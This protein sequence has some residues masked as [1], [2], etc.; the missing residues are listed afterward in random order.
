MP[1][2]IYY[3]SN[4]L[5]FTK[6]SLFYALVIIPNCTPEKDV[7]FE[8]LSTLHRS[9]GVENR[10]HTQ[11]ISRRFQVQTKRDQRIRK[12]RHKMHAAFAK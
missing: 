1:I 2:R 3:F 7:S 5:N 9:V 4:V 12:K 8:L 11:A 6:A 10:H